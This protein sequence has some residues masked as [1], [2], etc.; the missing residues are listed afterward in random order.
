MKCRICNLSQVC[1]VMGCHFLRQKL[2]R[3]TRFGEKGNKDS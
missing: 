1:A 3:M 2:Y